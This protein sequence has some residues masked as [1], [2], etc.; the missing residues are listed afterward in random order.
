MSLTL[1]KWLDICVL[2]IIALAA[3]RGWSQGLAVK[4]AQ[5]GALIAACIVA[6]TAANLLK[7]KLGSGFILPAFQENIPLP[8][9]PGTEIASAADSFAW[10]IVYFVSFLISL[11]VLRHLLK[12][13]NL[14]DHIPIIGAINRLGGAIVGFTVAFVLLYVVCSLIFRMMPQA[15]AGEWGVTEEIIEKTHI[16]K[17]FVPE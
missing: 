13:L 12:I 1:D 10:G 4:V 17:V 9:M 3:W 2:L 16:F 6:G 11:L 7:G 15:V 5:L 8:G 14:L